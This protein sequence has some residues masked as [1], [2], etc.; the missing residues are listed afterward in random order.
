MYLPHAQSQSTY[1]TPLHAAC[2]GKVVGPVVCHLIAHVVLVAAELVQ[3][4]QETAEHCTGAQ[5]QPEGEAQGQGQRWA[6]C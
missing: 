1:Q 2:L 4:V 6:R 3:A 5:R